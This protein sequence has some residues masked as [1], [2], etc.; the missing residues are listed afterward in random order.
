MTGP[1]AVTV[2]AG[3]SSLRLGV[4]S[5]ERSGRRRLR[6]LHVARGELEPHEAF[7][8]GLDSSRPDDVAF[9]AHRVVHGRALTA[10]SIIDDAALAEIERASRLA[11]LH[12]PPSLAWIREARSFFGPAVPEVAIF[13][14]GFFADL[15]AVAATYALPRDLNVSHGLRRYGFHGLAHE[16]LWRSWAAERGGR[17]ASARVVT[18]QLGSGCSMAAIEGG[19]PRDTSMG[20]T[21]LEGLVM[22]TRSGDI[23]PGL[24]LFLQREAG[25]SADALERILDERSGL[26]G[27]SG[28][29][30]DMRVLLA[31][32][33]PDARLAVSVFCYRARKYLGAFIAALGGADAVIVGGGIG[34][35]SPEVRAR[36]L[37]RMEWCGLQLDA[38]ANAKARGAT[39]IDDTRG[40]IEAWVFPTDEETLL[41]EH[42]VLAVERARD[43]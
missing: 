26:L 40:R 39:R 9:V 38:D 23:D 28:T 16:S 29:S 21:P 11:P 43:T 25:L 24:L 34:E 18:L 5:L 13:D 31:S 30:A 6:A 17:A 10:P 8:K 15:P 36:I 41:V 32:E 20:L 2:N 33:D 19:R 37:G 3:S 7:L 4:W 27:L 22:G 42:A 14:T 1:L 12:N 35:N